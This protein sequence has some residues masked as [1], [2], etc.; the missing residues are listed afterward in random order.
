MNVNVLMASSDLDVHELVK[1]LIN[2]TYKN[3]KIDKALNC[4]RMIQKLN[5]PDMTYNLVIMDYSLGQSEGMNALSCF[6]DHF[7]HMKERIVLVMDSTAHLSEDEVSHGIPCIVKPFS[8]DEFDTV[9]KK[10]CNA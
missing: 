8:L 3:A 9:V 7:P 1:D 6:K 2:I 10:V 5:D 4:D